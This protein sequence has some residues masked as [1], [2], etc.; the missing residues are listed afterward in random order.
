VALARRLRQEAEDLATLGV[1]QGELLGGAERSA[2]LVPVLRAAGV[3]DVELQAI[4]SAAATGLREAITAETGL[5][6]SER[7]AALDR[8]LASPAGE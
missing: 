6:H 8:R 3:L 5:A 2:A 1:D 7:L 4:L